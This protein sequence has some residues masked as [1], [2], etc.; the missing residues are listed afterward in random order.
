[1][2]M[3]DGGYNRKVYIGNITLTREKMIDACSRCRFR[4]RIKYPIDELWA[5][6][7]EQGSLGMGKSI[8]GA[9]SP[10]MVKDYKRTRHK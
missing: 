3:N 2:N 9:M 8:K 6:C 5:V 7:G 10:T 1:M 4:Q